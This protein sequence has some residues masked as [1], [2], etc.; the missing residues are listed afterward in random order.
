[1]KKAL[2]LSGGGARGAYQAGVLKGI[3]EIVKTKHLPVQMLNSVSIGSINAAFLAMYADD[4]SSGIN[5]LVELWSS[6]SCD[7]I[8]RV[9]NL[10]LIKSVIRN[11]FSL[12][13]H[14]RVKGGGYLLDTAPLKKLLDSN[15]D[16]K[17]INDNIDSG[18]LS[19]FEVAA[20]CYDISETISFIKSTLPSPC[21]K[22][23]RHF[24]CPATIGCQHILASS[25]FP[26]FFP[27]I[28]IDTM[29]YGDGG[30]RLSSP[31]R[32]A[33]KLGV[34][35]ILIIGTRKTPSIEASVNSTGIGDITFADVLGN[36]LN[37][38][39]LDNLDRDLNML[40]KI[41]DSI[42]LLPKDKWESSKLKNIQVLYLRP[43]VDLAKLAL[44]KQKTMPFLLRYLMSVFGT[45][46]QS[47]DLLSFL[48]FESAYCKELLDMGYDDAMRQKDEIN[49]FFTD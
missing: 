15:L 7:K 28:K 9:D 13:F 48:L 43:K 39:L 23:I 35:R 34:D 36:M 1:M 33:I 14:Y 11:V 30:L 18:L 22:K 4:F 47:G 44:P 25:A 16:F 19:D 12:T 40:S 21:W 46:E 8:F 37:A 26:L 24:A 5:R 41:N 45:K 27:A 6:L 32:A 17:K 3:N 29:H 10:S 2:Y 31:L 20:T 38:L 49:K 42:K